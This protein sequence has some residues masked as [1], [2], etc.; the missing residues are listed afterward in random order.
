MLPEKQIALIILKKISGDITPEEDNILQQWKSASP[1]HQVQYEQLSDLSQ[2]PDK[3]KK[4]NE[5]SQ[6][7]EAFNLPI[8]AAQRT[9]MTPIHRVHFLKKWGWAAAIII[10]LGAGAYLYITNRK[11]EAPVL[12][13]QE[14]P[15][16]ILPGSNKALLT[17]SDGTIITLDSAANGA[18]AQQ[19][20]SL[21]NKLSNGQI[22]Y[23]VKGLSHG[24]IMMNTMATPS[25][26]QYQ[27]ILPDGS[28]A[29]LNAASSIT[30]PAVFTGTDR[31]IK[32][33]GEIYLEIAKDKS[34]PFFVDVDGKSTVEVLG[35]SFNIN[36]Y[37]DEG[38][39]KT[40]LIE[41]SIK[42][43]SSIVLKPGQQAVQSLSDRKIISVNSS[44][45]IDQ[46]LAW[47][48]GIFNFQNADIR[49][50]MKQLERWYDIQVKYN[51]KI[52][53]FIFNGK[54]D[55]GVML[56]TILRFLSDYGVHTTLQGNVLIIEGN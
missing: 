4:Y 24:E 13:K 53:D 35:T 29:W 23:N 50:V 37:A 18:I 3:L 6:R 47:K 7:A 44:V 42:A 9:A 22:I 1:E 5:V 27:L 46:I 36:S 20:N 11:S 33:A 52:P 38:N 2:M 34:K 51:G 21:I 30:Y 12:A 31:K 16:D 25:G 55:R 8:V 15:T 41:G 10:L 17:L 19:G 26:G 40:T 43:N 39:I 32:V 48:N 56:S 49:S 28:K 14:K 54:M 45:N